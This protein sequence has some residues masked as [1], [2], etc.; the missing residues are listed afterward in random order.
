MAVKKFENLLSSTISW[1]GVRSF[2][3]LMPRARGYHYVRGANGRKRRVY[4]SGFKRPRRGTT[5]RGVFARVYGRG[6]YYARRPAHPTRQQANR[7]LAS[8]GRR[9]TGLSVLAFGGT[10]PP[11]MSM[12]KGEVTVEHREYIQDISSSVP[13]IPE[14]FPLNPGMMQTFPWLSQLADNFEEWIPEAILFEY[15]TTSSNTVVN[16][17]NSNPGLG[18]VIIAT[19]YNSLNNQFGNKQQMENYENAVS[20]DPSRSVIH[21]I[22]CARRQTPVQP[23]YVR[24]GALAVSATQSNDLRFYDHGV[25]TIA[26]VG[27]QTN[28]FVIGELW[29]TYRIKFLKPRLQTGVGNNEQGNVDYFSLGNATTLPAVPFGTSTALQPPNEGSTIGGVLSPGICVIA[30]QQNIG[31]TASLGGPHP[32]PIFGFAG[33]QVS[34]TQINSVANTYY[35][36]PG[37][38]SGIFECVY[39]QVY[40]VA[41]GNALQVVTATEATTGCV[42]YNPTGSAPAIQNNTAATTTT[43]DMSVFYIRVTGNYARF[44]M[45]GTPGMTTPA[46]GQFTIQQLPANWPGA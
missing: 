44:S 40:G 35:F 7:P 15:K 43:T 6:A 20:V 28:N 34:P 14:N 30:D 12:K 8:R 9:G 25:T 11:K 29:I 33:G 22:E 27:Q 32:F 10:D 26:T 1:N 5:P 41:G 16:V 39:T 3:F 4:S 18:T 46:G 42:A 2:S 36:P 23:L 21:P 45:T 17:T 13:F 38:S 19:Q 31:F 37:I 24:T